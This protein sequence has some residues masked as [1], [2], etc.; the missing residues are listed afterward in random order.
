MVK[1]QSDYSFDGLSYSE[2]KELL[3]NFNR[4]LGQYSIYWDHVKKKDLTKLRLALSRVKSEADVQRYLQSHPVYLIQHLG[5][6]HDRWVIPKKRLGSEHVPDF[7]V[8]ERCSSGVDWY[9]LE[10]ES[11]HQKMFNK[12]GDPSHALTHAIRQIQDWRSWLES[13]IC[14]ATRSKSSNGLGLALI[15]PKLDGLIFIGRRKDTNSKT[16]TLRRQ[17]QYDLR[18]EIHT[19]DYLI[20]ILRDR[21]CALEKCPPPTLPPAP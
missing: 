15:T 11:P 3:D 17:M 14:Y 10:L 13:N 4:E 1:E 16:N 7:L 20:D 12:N 9:A 5:G 2:F 8:G 6:G 21:I 19:Y 18:I